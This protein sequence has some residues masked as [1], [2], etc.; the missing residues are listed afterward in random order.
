MALMTTL[1]VR[2][3]ETRNEHGRPRKVFVYQDVL[4]DGTPENPGV[5]V[6]G[7]ES[8]IIEDGG[9]VIAVGK[10]RYRIAAT[11]EILVAADPN[12]G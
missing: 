3:I 2:I 11:G 12:A 8:L 4:Q 10:G 7:P 6:R 1:L 5:E 9:E